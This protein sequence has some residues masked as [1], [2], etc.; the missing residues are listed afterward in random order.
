MICLFR[1]PRFVGLTPKT[2]RLKESLNI[3]VALLL[4]VLLARSSVEALEERIIDKSI[5]HLRS[6]AQREWSEFPERAESTRL[7][8]QFPATAAGVEH[9]LRLR[10][11]DVK[12]PWR[13]LINNKELG[14]LS[15][16]END[17]ISIWPV[18]A[19]M[20][21]GGLN[22][23]EIVPGSDRVDDILAGDIRLYDGPVAQA[24]GAASA[25]IT[26][27][28]AASGQPL[29]CRLTVVDSNGSLL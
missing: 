17:K 8:L 1:K 9:T 23:L 26:V 14:R 10:Q 20:L 5:H 3:G 12:Q 15:Q 29:P 13:L 25:E 11:R 21:V 27:V 28:D 2:R 19:G 24:I 4:L 7:D 22:R 16:D 18:P 6:G